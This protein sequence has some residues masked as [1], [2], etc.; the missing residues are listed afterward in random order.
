MKHKSKLILLFLSS[1]LMLAACGEKQS[2][3][4]I[5]ATSSDHSTSENVSSSQTNTNSS[6]SN[7]SSSNVSSSKETPSSVVSSSSKAEE[8]SSEN[9]SSEAKT[10]SEES[11]EIPSSS[12]EEVSS[13]SELPSSSKDVS[14][15][16]G[17]SSSE[18]SSGSEEEISSSSEP[19]PSSEQSSETPSSSSEEQSSPS[20]EPLN[21]YTVAFDSRGGSQ[22]PTQTVAEGDVAT[23]PDDP[24]K[25][26]YIFGGWY[27]STTY[28]KEF[29]FEKP[30]TTDYV[31][32]AKWTSSSETGGDT[33]PEPEPTI[34]YVDYWIAGDF[35]SW[36]KD[37][38]IQ[39]V[40]NPDGNDLGM[41]LG[42]EIEANKAFKVTNY[43]EW[44]GYR[45][46]LSSV[47]TCD[48]NG[49]IV[50]KE[51]ATYNI[52]LNEYKQ[53]WVEKVSA[54]STLSQNNINVGVVI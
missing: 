52:Y 32:F 17:Q 12:A 23:K 2:D 51:T 46:E 22:V 40:E 7:K 14:S 20:S 35:C 13:S 18:E 9:S 45:D 28:I 39:M 43:T 33:D 1:S 30:I 26:G 6:S 10:S 49:N 3:S 44:Y 36:S 24:T 31:L 53:V 27:L 8:S 41:K 38:A 48:N 25:D 29:D 16:E 15:S 11:S 54:S 50:V 37:G 47:A 34:N 42:V 4:T 5:E 21:Y 19:E